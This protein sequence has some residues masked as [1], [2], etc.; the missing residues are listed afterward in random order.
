MPPAVAVVAAAS[1]TLVSITKIFFIS[2][3]IFLR[4]SGAKV[5]LLFKYLLFA[6]TKLTKFNGI[7]TKTCT[8]VQFCAGFAHQ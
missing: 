6:H 2:L 7:C 1:I 8:N 4:K 5:Y 3:N